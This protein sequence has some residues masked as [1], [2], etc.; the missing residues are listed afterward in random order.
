M[1]CAVC[2]SSLL[3]ISGWGSSDLSRRESHKPGQVPGVHGTD[4]G[5]R[6]GP[7]QVLGHPLPAGENSGYSDGRAG[8]EQSRVTGESFFFPL[9]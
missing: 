1:C 9:G 8:L 5:G 7:V 6:K 3:L 2:I 4:P